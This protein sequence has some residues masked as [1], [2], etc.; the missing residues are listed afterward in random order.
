M[1]TA[2]ECLQNKDILY[3]N[4]TLVEGGV[5][6]VTQAMREYVIEVIDEIVNNRQVYFYSKMGTDD[7]DVENDMINVLK[8]QLK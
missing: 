8:Q 1:K 2:L 6:K 7:I 3:H 4:D 5:E